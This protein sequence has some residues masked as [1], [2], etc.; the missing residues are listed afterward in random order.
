MHAGNGRPIYVDPP[1]LEGVEVMHPMTLQSTP[2]TRCL[3]A[4]LSA[5]LQSELSR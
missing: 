2:N 1:I 3:A 4:A 5:A